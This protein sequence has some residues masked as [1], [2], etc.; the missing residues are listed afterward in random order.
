[1]FEDERGDHL[2][3][4][5]KARG[6]SVKGN[7][8]WYRVDFTKSEWLS[9]RHVRSV[10]APMP[11]CADSK[12]VGQ[13]T[14]ATLSKRSGPSTSDNKVG[15]LR[16]GANVVLVCKAKSQSIKGNKLWYQTADR[17]WVAAKYIKNVGKA[18]VGAT[19]RPNFRQHP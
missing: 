14:T 4:G 6:T 9:A 1:M 13:V 17:N 19:C 8:L 7:D 16:R 15:D 5:C 18:P 12:A 10:G 11:W 2:A 3:L